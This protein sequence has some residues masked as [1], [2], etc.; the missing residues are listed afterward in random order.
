MNKSERI[1]HRRKQL[2][3]SIHELGKR[4]GVSHS[5][6]SQWENNPNIEIKSD[7]FFKLAKALGVTPA[8]LLTGS[9]N[10]PSQHNDKGGVLG[11]F[12]T[13]D[14]RTPLNDDDVELPFFKEV[15]LSAGIGSEVV[16][17][18]N[19]FKLR[20]SKSTLKRH[21]IDPSNAACVQ[22]NGDSMEPILPNG[23]TV[24]IDTSK[25]QVVDGKMYAIDH[26]GLLRVKVLH[27]VPGGLRIKSFNSDEHPDETYKGSELE[28]IKVIGKVFWSAAFYF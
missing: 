20:F 19:G 22:I 8:Y 4:V 6:I 5:A 21:N 11:E 1:R 2:K 28:D 23:S 17:E 25:T 7:K 13:W 18:D 16:R 10:E 9:E 26:S 24:G 27:R 14:S 12:E 15:E 3:L